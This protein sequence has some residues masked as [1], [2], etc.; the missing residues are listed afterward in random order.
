MDE[1]S[2]T[3][4]KEQLSPTTALAVYGTLRP[5]E[6]NHFVVKQIPGHWVEATVRGYLYE[7]TWGPAEGYPGLSLDDDGH[8]VPVSVLV[9]DVLSDHIWQVDRFEGDGYE[10]RPV[11]VF[12]RE[13]VDRLGLASIYE[14]KTQVD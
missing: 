10:R 3:S 4:A 13:G 9:S 8:L 14:T 11:S 5:G 7:I 12:D 2:A 6:V 1:T